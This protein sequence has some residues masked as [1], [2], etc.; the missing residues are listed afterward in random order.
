[1]DLSGFKKDNLDL[2]RIE[3]NKIASKL[4]SKLPELKA[5]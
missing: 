5:H 4:H 1:M 3:L 2:A